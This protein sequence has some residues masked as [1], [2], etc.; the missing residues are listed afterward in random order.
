MLD[1]G[2]AASDDP[3]FRVLELDVSR[4][5]AVVQVDLLLV[6]LVQDE[7]VGQRPQGQGCQGFLSRVKL[8]A[9]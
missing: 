7:V 5:G 3:L 6:V 2:A 8:S 9:I 4:V 1:L